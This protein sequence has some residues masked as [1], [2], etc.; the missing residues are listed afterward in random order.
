[1]P[2]P[3]RARLS[4][5]DRI[6]NSREFKAVYAHRARAADG[7]L[8][9][10]AADSGGV[11]TRLG[12]SVSRKCGGAVERN[13]IRRLVREAFRQIRS[14]FPTGIDIVVVPLGRDYTFAEVVDRLRSLVAEA[15]R[16]CRRA[17]EAQDGKADA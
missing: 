6:L 11:R 9:V 12:I 14:E 13:R 5:R 8:V 17:R 4:R 15:V 3:G 2:S 1:M 10:Y 7:R 16:R